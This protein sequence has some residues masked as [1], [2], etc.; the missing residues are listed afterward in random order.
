MTTEDTYA[1]STTSVCPAKPFAKDIMNFVTAYAADKV[2]EPS[3]FV[4]T[5]S[6]PASWTALVNRTTSPC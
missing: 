6:S 3:P 5:T 2:A 4:L 1:D